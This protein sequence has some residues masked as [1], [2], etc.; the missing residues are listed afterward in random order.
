MEKR[1]PIRLLG[2]G[3]FGVVYLAYHIE[4]GITAVKLIMKDSNDKQERE[5]E[6]A[7]WISNKQN[8]CPFI[9]KYLQYDYNRN[10]DIIV[11]EYANLMTLDIIA[12]QPQI[13]LP[14][15]S[16]RALMKQILEGTRVIHASGLI[17]RDIKCNNIL[18][19]TPPGSE[20]VYAKIA[21]FGLAKKKD[22]TD[23]KHY[24]AGTLPY[25][26]CTRTLQKTNYL[27]IKS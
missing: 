3:S 6:S 7:I 18:L 13:Y 2:H 4:Y 11:T 5:W 23:E 1:I 20:R 26:V 14:S 19:H 27:N 15:Y 22:L 8:P 24:T 12:K 21:D 10:C 16:L 9:L 25:L 17:H